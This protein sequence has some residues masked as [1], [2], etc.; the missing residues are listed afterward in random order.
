MRRTAFVTIGI[1]AFALGLGAG[2][3]WQRQAAVPLLER[4]TLLT[5][6][7]ALPEFK[8][9]DQEGAPFTNERLKGRWTLAFFGY[10][11][12]PDVCPLTLRVFKGLYERLGET[13]Y[14]EDTQVLFVSVDPERDRPEQLKRYVQYFDP[15][16]LGVTGSPQELS[17]LTQAL[18]I[19]YELRGTGKDYLV[20]HSAAVVLI[21]P[22]GRRHA[23]F[24]PPHEVP[25]LARDYLAI[26]RAA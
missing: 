15:S 21:D 18:G 5:S 12:C 4:A 7:Q 25:V 19:Y 26:R 11:H 2:Y 22:E 14:R 17:K 8:L 13:G 16:F 9:Q 10:T 3:L 1:M 23:V 6:P 20:D 24:S